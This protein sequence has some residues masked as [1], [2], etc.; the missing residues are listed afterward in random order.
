[1]IFVIDMGDQHMNQ[2]S[3][4]I[5]QHK[6]EKNLSRLDLSNNRIADEGLVNLCKSICDSNVEAL[7]V[8][9]NRL[10]EKCA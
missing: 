6:Y 1:M 2:I 7:N 8:S 4:L 5:K 10:T 9:N 3:S